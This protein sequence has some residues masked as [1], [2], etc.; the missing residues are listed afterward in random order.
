MNK[1]LQI[2]IPGELAKEFNYV[3]HK[4]A[5]NKSELIRQWIEKFVQE[6]K[7]SEKN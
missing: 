6:Q 5:I 7:G 1:I 2:R 4:K 3:T